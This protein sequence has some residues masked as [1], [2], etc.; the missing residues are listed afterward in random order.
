M[1][2]LLVSVSR[3]DRLVQPGLPLPEPDEDFDPRSWQVSPGSSRSGA[4]EPDTSP[5]Q[6]DLHTREVAWACE[7]WPPD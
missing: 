1:A 3:S 5:R 2:T 6:E 7:W 4:L